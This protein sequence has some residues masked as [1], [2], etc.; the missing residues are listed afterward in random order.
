[1][2]SGVKRRVPNLLLKCSMQQ[3]HNELITS[4]DDDRLIGTRHDDT[5][6]VISSDTILRSLLPPQL[7]PMKYHQNIIC[8][9]AIC[10]T[11]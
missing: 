3:L 10:N 8:G 4:P 7:C 11:S 9:C 2:E 1:M 6:D 5:N